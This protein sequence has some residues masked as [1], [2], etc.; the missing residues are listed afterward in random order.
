[1]GGGG[2]VVGEIP[3]GG[4]DAGTS[5]TPT[6]TDSGTATDAGTETD[7]GTDAGAPRTLCNDREIILKQ[8]RAIFDGR[9]DGLQAALD[10]RV[11]EENWKSAYTGDTWGPHPATFEPSAVPP[12]C[13]D[14]STFKR[15]LVLAAVNYWVEQDLNYCHHHIPGWTPPN[16]GSYRNSTSGSTSGGGGSL[17]T[18]TPNRFADG[19]QR[20]TT[21][22]AHVCSATETNYCDSADEI[23]SADLSKQV[24]WQGLDCSDFTSWVWN[25]AGLTTAP[26]PTGIG[27]QACTTTQAPGTLLD[28]NA[29]NFDEVQ[30]DGTT[31]G[32]RL[33]AGDLLYVLST[34]TPDVAHVITWTG[35]RWRDLQASSAK[36][37]YETSKL[38]EAGSRLGG[39]LVKY[40]LSLAQ[41][42][43]ANPYMIVDS[44]YA[45]PAYRPF[46]GWYRGSLTH[47]RRIVDA[48]EVAADAVLAPLRFAL[49]TEAAPVSREHNGTPIPYQ[50]LV[51]PKYAS[52]PAHEG[53]R[54]YVNETFNSCARSTAP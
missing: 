24:Q 33:R 21:G 47:V 53:H 17:M 4:S 16:F 25:F 7:S 50:T 19:H 31:L 30:T 41:L 13:T 36:G 38:G 48:D 52:A 11:T 28:I 37:K 51:S 1:M 44:H 49:D 43:A 42:D 14:G 12:S 29:A 2:V 45:G 6:T 9:K 8:A 3:S 39:D 18:C 15:E 20:V 54:L 40:G 34:S 27:T 26:M 5:T 35:L 32:S 22:A 23:E 10:H 46:N